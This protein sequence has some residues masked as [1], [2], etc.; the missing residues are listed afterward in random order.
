MP[1]R[2]RLS[3][4]P[5]HWEQTGINV[6]SRP[7]L[8][9]SHWQ[10]ASAQPVSFAKFNVAPEVP[11]FNDETYDQ[12]LTDENWSKDET[13]Y[14]LDLYKESNGKWPVIIDRYERPDRTME[15]LKARFYSISA[16]LLELKTP[17]SSMAGSE[18]ALHET[19][20]SFNPAQ[21]ASRKRLAEGH[22]QR[23]QNEV[24]EEAVLL[25]E[26][27]R[28]MA[29]QS[30]LENDRE[31]LRRR[32]DHPRANSNGYQYSTSQALNGLWQQLLA[33]D[34]MRKNQRLRPVGPMP[35]LPTDGSTIGQTPTSGRPRESNAGLAEPSPTS[36]RLSDKDMLRFGVSQ[37]PAGDKLPSSVTFASD[38]LSKLRI[39]K[40]TI[41]TDRIHA[42][43]THIGVPEVLPL[44]TPAVTEQF[45][46]LM[47][48]VN[49]LLDLRKVAEKEEQELRVRQA[50]AGQ[51]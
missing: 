16:K 45:E 22:L 3:R 27:Q 28:I 15:D 44:P 4:P 50:E 49:T 48:K 5:A 51:A 40:S 24:D 18:Y 31:E 19:L 1:A 13:Q 23:R 38:K 9:L 25:N 17:K 10:K 43:L 34:R 8:S 32:L 14:L 26:L 39:A 7:D 42:I 30:S 21:E 12:H 41:Q 2:A 37:P 33:A 20:T 11:T 29:N 47:A 6:E 46:Q 35:S 36:T